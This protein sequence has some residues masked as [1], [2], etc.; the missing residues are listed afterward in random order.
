MECN[1]FPLSC[2]PPPTCVHD[3]PAHCCQYVS[4]LCRLSHWPRPSV[5]EPLLIQPLLCV[6]VTSLRLHTA[7]FRLTSLTSHYTLSLM[8]PVRLWYIPRE[9]AYQMPVNL[10]STRMPPTCC[11]SCIEVL[12][13]T[14]AVLCYLLYGF[15]WAFLF[16]VYA[17]IVSVTSIKHKQFLFFL[18]L[19]IFLW[20]SNRRS[21]DLL[22]YFWKETS[23]MLVNGKSS[24]IDLQLISVHPHSYSAWHRH[25]WSFV[26]VLRADQQTHISI[27]IW[28]S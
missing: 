21:F 3:W 15:F 5:T 18:Y 20:K 14:S 19:G 11:Q 23:L 12:E 25:L 13:V 6:F 4:S 8:C 10:S 2:P 1:H 26:D 17:I 28:D 22:K 16:N 7:L 9:R 27:L 24:A